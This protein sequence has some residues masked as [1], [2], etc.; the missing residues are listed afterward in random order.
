[1]SRLGGAVADGLTPYWPAAILG[2]VL[3]Q[4]NS[5]AILSNIVFRPKP[6][7]HLTRWST[8]RLSNQPVAEEDGEYAGKGKEPAVK[9]VIA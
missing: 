4:L 6:Q 7:T 5:R 9:G 2:H 8:N 3:L 1:M